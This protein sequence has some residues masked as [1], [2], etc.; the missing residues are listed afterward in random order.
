[1]QPESGD[2]GDEK[3]AKQV[4]FLLVRKSHSIFVVDDLGRKV[5]EVTI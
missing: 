2:C 4:H 1:M 5:G 3:M